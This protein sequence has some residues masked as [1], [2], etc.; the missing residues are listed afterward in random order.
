MSNPSTIWAQLSLPLSAVG[1]IPFVA[2]DGVTI[3]TDVASF[4]Y[5]SINDRL[6]LGN[7]LTK[8]YSANL[9]AAANTV[10]LNTPTGRVAVPATRSSMVVA[11]SC[12]TATSMVIAVL[13]TADAT[14]TQIL[15]VVP[16]LTV[17][18]GGVP[19]FAVTFNA[20]CTAITTFSYMVIN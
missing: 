15:R 2:P 10:T 1:S 17:G 13:E 19:G 16:G 14:A 8:R 12:I 4:T 11:N 6:Y 9:T 5:D 7:Q 20:A 18:T 3:N